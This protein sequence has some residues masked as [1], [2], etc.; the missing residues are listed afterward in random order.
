MLE[1]CNTSFQ[2]HF[3]VGGDEFAAL[4]NLAQAITAP[5]LAAAVNS[6][7]L[8]E[9]R[10]W[11]ETRVALFQTLHRQPPRDRAQPAASARASTSATGGSSA[12]S[13][14]SS[15][16]TSRASA[17]CWR[18]EPVEDPMAKVE[19]G[20][21]PELLA[22]RHH[23]GTVYRWNR[24]CY[25]VHD[26]VAHLRIENRVLPAGTDG[27]RPDGERRVLL[28]PDVGPLR[29]PPR[30]DEGPLRST[31]PG[32]TSSRPRATGSAHSSPGSK[33]APTPR[34]T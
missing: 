30:R 12:R 34:P 32:P 27:R 15:A 4:Y 6:P 11:H 5:V 21:V 13:W 19:R 26:G 31:T 7:I 17:W 29:D 22:L 24:P 9:H 25:G 10:L 3:Q 20:E 16:R 14:R 1:S 2:I 23:N 18:P 33:A 8:A 28:R